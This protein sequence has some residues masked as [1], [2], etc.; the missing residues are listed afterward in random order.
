MLE[1]I[2]AAPL[3]PRLIPTRGLATALRPRTSPG[4]WRTGLRAGG[5]KGDSAQTGPSRAAAKRV[6]T[7]SSLPCEVRLCFWL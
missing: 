3:P 4:S 6:G 1:D 7:A 2:A 5:S